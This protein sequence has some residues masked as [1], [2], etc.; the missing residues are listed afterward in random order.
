M[1]ELKERLDV[2]DVFVDLE[3][4]TV[5][6]PPEFE[7][8]RQSE[9][10]M[11]PSQAGSVLGPSGPTRIPARAPARGMKGNEAM[12]S[13][14]AG[15]RVEAEVETSTGKQK[16]HGLFSGFGHARAT[17]GRNAHEAENGASAAHRWQGPE[18]ID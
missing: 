9:R 15:L 17:S 3:S 12:K 8:P 2:M 13:R 5:S 6:P 7:S 18:L 10:D 11:A 1:R 16:Q 14:L 4:R